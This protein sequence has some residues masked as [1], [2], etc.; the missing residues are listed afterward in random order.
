[1]KRVAGIRG[2][3]SKAGGAMAKRG[4]IKSII[5][6]F[7]KNLSLPKDAGM[8]KTIFELKWHW[9]KFG[10]TETW[11]V[12]LG[13]LKSQGIKEHHLSRCVYSI[14]LAAKFGI[15]YPNG[16]SP[17]LYVGEGRLKQRVESHRKWLR[18]ME[19][20][21]GSLGLQLAVATPRVQNNKVAYKEAEAALIQH[22]LEKYHSAPFKNSNIEYQKFGHSFTKASLNEAL[23]PG[24]GARYHWAVEPTH[25]NPFRDVF[26]KTHRTG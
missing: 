25:I 13:K 3:F 2:I 23:T 12:V 8:A 19:K 14:R 4:V 6:Y 22:F 16:V 5:A 10:T 26:R 7:H 1:M 17:T 11:S 21:F 24:N 20:T 18:E 15:K 9:I